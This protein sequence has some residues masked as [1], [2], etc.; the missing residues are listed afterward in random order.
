MSEILYRK[1]GSHYYEVGST[2]GGFPADGVWLVTN[3]RRNTECMARISEIPSLPESALLYRLPMKNAILDA[4]IR[5]MNKRDDFV[6]LNDMAIIA[7]DSAAEVLENEVRR[8]NS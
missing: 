7:C 5:R 8:R 2:F 3:G 1:R 6:S 4:I